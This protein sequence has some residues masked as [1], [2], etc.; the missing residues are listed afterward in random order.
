[1]RDK[2]LFFS[3]EQGRCTF[4][5]SLLIADSQF[6]KYITAFSP[7]RNIFLKNLIDK[8]DLMC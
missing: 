4:N 5:Y 1:M 7:V 3:V 2:E 6:K 8:R